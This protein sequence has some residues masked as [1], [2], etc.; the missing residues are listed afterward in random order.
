[1]T[2]VTKSQFTPVQQAIIDSLKEEDS[3]GL[4]QP[5]QLLSIKE[6]KVYTVTATFNQNDK[7]T[8]QERFIEGQ[9]IKFSIGKAQTYRPKR[10]NLHAKIGQKSKVQFT[11]T[12]LSSDLRDLDFQRAAL[13]E[14]KRLQL[15]AESYPYDAYDVQRQETYKHYEIVQNQSTI[16]IFSFF[17]EPTLTPK[18][19]TK[20]YVALS[21][22]SYYFDPY[23]DTI[24]ESKRETQP[25]QANTNSASPNAV[26]NQ[27][28]N[29]D[30]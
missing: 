24:L 21:K 8:E 6:N 12:K 9:L 15:E 17:G 20:Q 5:I 14:N 22:T 23:A 4:E 16:F 10:N 27:I 2:E 30:L 28:D 29:D 1:M 26:F 13:E 19:V 7:L 25:A 18:T 3:S 11:R